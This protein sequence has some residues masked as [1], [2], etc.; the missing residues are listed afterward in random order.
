MTNPSTLAGLAVWIHIRCEVGRTMLRA[1]PACECPPDYEITR[2]D[3][4]A[5]PP[6]RTDSYICRRHL[7]ELAAMAYP[8]VQCRRCGRT[9]PT[10]GHAVSNLRPVR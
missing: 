2:H 9:F 4:D 1:R 8:F 10:F 5:P 7:D 6:F 3:C